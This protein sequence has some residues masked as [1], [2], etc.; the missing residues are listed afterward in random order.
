MGK[1]LLLTGA[2]GFLGSHMIPELVRQ[3]W[4]VTCL[5][6]SQ[7][8]MSAID[9]IRSLI[10]FVCA[11]Q[12]VQDVM[13]QVTVA[14]GD[15]AHPQLGMDDTAYRKLQRSVDC[16]FHCAAMTTFDPA[17][18]QRQW[19]VNVE[20]TE[21]MV[22]FAL[23]TPA[24]EQFHYVSTAYVAGDRTDLVREEELDKGQ[25]FLNGYEKSKFFAEKMLRQYVQEQGLRVT[26]YRPSIIVGDSQSGKTILFNGMYLFM[27]FFEVAKHSQRVMEQN[28]K[29]IIPV[30]C[31]GN[32]ACTKNFVHIDYVVKTIG[33]LFRTPA[34][35]G[36][37][38]H[39]THDNPP[40]ME[41]LRQCIE[42]VLD[43]SGISLVDASSF[44]REPPN[45]L[46]LVFQDQI[47][48]YAAYLMT[49]PR[50]ERRAITAVLPP[51]DIPPCSPMDKPAVEKLFH[52]AL[53][54]RWGRKKI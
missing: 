32:P 37:T 47:K 49:E 1:Q 27:R 34:A 24:A 31:L 42:Q 43:I 12:E 36:G 5:A 50:F 38:Y 46:E 20:G 22:R 2:T 13:A 39:I 9:R 6:R 11:P 19:V 10:E 48:P 21:H 3:G 8:K 7:K 33:A 44:E 41:M 25:G 29:V 45:E 18:A 52:Y 23:G 15:V 54:S 35:H 30:R 40:T 16:I 26:F 4:Q 14:E 17:Q 53:Q 28:G 51:Q